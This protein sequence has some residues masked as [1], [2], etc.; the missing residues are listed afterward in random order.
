MDSLRVRKIT[1]KRS[2]SVSPRPRITDRVTL[3]G[4]RK[5]GDNIKMI[6]GAQVEAN[7]LQATYEEC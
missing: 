2:I 1:D 3:K 5:I 4:D 7:Y 6:L